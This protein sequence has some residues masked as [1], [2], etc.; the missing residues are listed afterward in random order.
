MRDERRR[1]RGEEKRVKRCEM[2]IAVEN[3][4]SG[5]YED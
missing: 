3:S 4:G 2:R 1:L 5:R